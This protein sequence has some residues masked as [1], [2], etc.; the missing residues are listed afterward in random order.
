M[1]YSLGKEGPVDDEIVGG[2]GGSKVIVARVPRL[3]IENNPYK[4]VVPIEE[5]TDAL[6]AEMDTFFLLTDSSVYSKVL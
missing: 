5:D 6:A 2:V 4:V 1:F 3:E